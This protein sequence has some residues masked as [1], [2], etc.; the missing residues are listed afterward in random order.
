[1]HNWESAMLLNGNL[2]EEKGRALD[3]Y[4]LRGNYLKGMLPRICICCGEPM[5]PG[6]NDLS[7][8]PNICA[9]C[10]SILDGM[11]E[12]D[13]FELE[14]PLH[15]QPSPGEVQVE[16]THRAARIGHSPSPR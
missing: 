1:M 6:A 4:C 13:D 15:E 8:N 14:K 2:E 9:S 7:R 12:R 16:E 10:S 5:A 11:E 3:G